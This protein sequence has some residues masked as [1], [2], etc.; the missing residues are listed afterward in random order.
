VSI[1]GLV[2]TET[3]ARLLGVSAR[4][5]NQLVDSGDIAKA[6]R[7]LYDRV[8]IER[9]LITRRGTSQR[10]WDTSTAWAAVAILSGRRGGVGWLAE[11]STYRLEATLRTI[12]VAELVGKARERARV[13]VFAGHPS[14]A[15]VLGSDV[16]TRDWNILGLADAIGDGVDGYVDSADLESVVDRYALVASTSGNITLRA[17]DFD[18]D[19]VRSLAKSSDVL[20]ALDAAGSIDARLRGTG[21]RV[22][23]RAL[24]RLSDQRGW[25][26]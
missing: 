17:A 25:S 4:R 24:E 16:V 23:E 15:R 13:H 5:V 21:E 6:S 9:Y 12:T 19:T 8:S 1:D 14:V 3:A 11:R 2:D 20:V 7:G 22:L 26:R 10:A 18:I